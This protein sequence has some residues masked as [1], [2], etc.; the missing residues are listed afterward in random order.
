[1]RDALVMSVMND[2][3]ST[4]PSSAQIAGWTE[5]ECRMKRL[6]I[7]SLRVML[8][9]CTDLHHE[10]EDAFLTHPFI[11]NKRPGRLAVPSCNTTSMLGLS[12]LSSSHLFSAAPSLPKCAL[13][14]PLRLSLPWSACQLTTSEGVVLDADTTPPYIHSAIH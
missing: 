2:L 1:M 5:S 3:F 11:P 8:D 7:A 10:L 4:S 6:E 14:S 13:P 9:N 12:P